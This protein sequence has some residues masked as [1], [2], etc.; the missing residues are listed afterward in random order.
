MQYFDVCVHLLSRF[1]IFFENFITV[2][3][4]LYVINK[5]SCKIDVFLCYVLSFDE[6]YGYR[7]IACRHL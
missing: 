2:V 6:F 4:A 3:I 5:I 1:E 7:G